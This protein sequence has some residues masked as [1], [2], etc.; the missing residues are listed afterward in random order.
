MIFSDDDTDKNYSVHRCFTAAS[1]ISELE[2]ED[3]IYTRRTF[4]GDSVFPLLASDSDFDA[5]KDTKFTVTMGQSGMG[6]LTVIFIFFLLLGI[7]GAVF[8]LTTGVA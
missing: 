8:S 5:T 7:G 2:D 3:T 6:L 4:K 1:D